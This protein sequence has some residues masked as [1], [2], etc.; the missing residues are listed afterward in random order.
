MT[1]IQNDGRP[2]ADRVQKIHALRATTISR[3]RDVLTAEQKPK[4]DQMVSDQDERMRQR[5]Q[6]QAPPSQQ[7]PS[8]GSKPPPPASDKKNKGTAT[9][10][11]S[12]PLGPE[13]NPG[14]GVSHLTRS[15]P[16]QTMG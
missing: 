10:R 15:N 12:A 9:A 13:K 14:L 4:F 5:Q 6:M 2:R 11:L 16:P 1:I 3:V 8:G 7:P